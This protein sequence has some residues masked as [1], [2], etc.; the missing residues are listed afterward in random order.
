MLCERT[1]EYRPPPSA[2]WQ[3]AKM[4]DMVIT[5]EQLTA[6]FLAAQAAVL[7]LAAVVANRQ[8]KEA[9]S[10]REEQSRPFVGI[11]FET[12][13]GMIHLVVTNTGRTMA[14]DVRF[15]FSPDLTS[16]LDK[17]REQDPWS[18]ASLKMFSDGIPTL[19]PGKRIVTLFDSSFQRK[20]TEFPDW[21]SVEVSYDNASKRQSYRET[22]DLDFGIYWGLIRIEEKD[23]HDI[24]RR[25][26]ELVKEV[27]KW[28]A[29]GGGFLTLRPT[30]V[31]ER[32][33]RVEQE[34]D[35]R[36]A[37]RNETPPT[38]GETPAVEAI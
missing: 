31:A 3:Q 8:L 10:T 15:K 35:E 27:K 38:A 16:S 33:K 29:S 37:R 12:R 23:A 7:G 30:D 17:P 34:W 19:P 1:F 20:P 4:G 6:G 36:E 26:E 21:Y 32:R 11:D 22:I 14:R 9:Q 25:L 24:H 18:I 2:H 5:T 28:S 13:K